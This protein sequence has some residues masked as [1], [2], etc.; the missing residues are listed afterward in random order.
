[1]GMVARFRLS[2]RDLERFLAGKTALQERAQHML[3]ELYNDGTVTSVNAQGDTEIN[4]ADVL[5]DYPFVRL[6]WWPIDDRTTRGLRAYE[7]KLAW[8]LGEVKQGASYFVLV[9]GSGGG[10]IVSP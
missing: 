3:E 7:G 8:N 9:D 10:Y 5:R 2:P 4:S 6:A 1:M